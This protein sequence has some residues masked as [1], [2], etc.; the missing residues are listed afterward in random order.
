M[1]ASTSKSPTSTLKRRAAGSNESS[2]ASPPSAAEELSIR[3]LGG[4]RKRRVRTGCLQ[5]RIRRVKCQEGEAIHG[6]SGEKLP[7]RWCATRGV[8]CLYPAAPTGL[9]RNVEGTAEEE[10]SHLDPI[11]VAAEG[12]GKVKKTKEGVKKRRKRSTTVKREDRDEEDEDDASF[13]S[14]DQLE[15]VPRATTSF[16]TLQLPINTTTSYNPSWSTGL[17]GCP[18]LD[19]EGQVPTF[20]TGYDYRTG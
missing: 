14:Q 3:V 1:R 9:S 2:S 15:L 17:P 20:W 12:W 18:T 6:P 16:A 4:P 19:F 13:G 7:C 8:E 10:S 11:A 5:C